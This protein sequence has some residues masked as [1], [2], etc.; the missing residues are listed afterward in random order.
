[1]LHRLAPALA[2]LCALAPLSADEVTLT[3]GSS[4]TGVVVMESDA[5]IA[6]DTM[7]DG[8]RTT[9]SIPKL[10]FRRLYAVRSL[11]VILISPRPGLMAMVPV[12]DPICAF[13]SMARSAAMSPML[14]CAKR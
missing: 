6:L 13:Q 3:D 2:A 5:G 4:L 8:T 12:T 11:R 7:V 14:G 9:L 10:R 1:M